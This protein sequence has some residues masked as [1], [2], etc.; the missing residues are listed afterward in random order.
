M[1]LQYHTL[2]HIPLADIAATFN[3]AFADYHVKLSIT[4]ERLVWKIKAE[5]ID[6]SL[7]TGVYDNKQMVGFILHATEERNGQ[8]LVYNGG[9]GVIPAYR[10]KQLVQGMY[11]SIQPL[12]KDRRVDALVLECIT[13]NIPAIK[14]YQR[15]GFVIKRELNCYKGVP[16]GE[17]AHT[18]VQ[19][20]SLGFLEDS[21][22]FCD[23]EPTWQ[24]TNNA[25]RRAPEEHQIF[26][27][28]K[29]G[30]VVAYAV[31]YPASL[32]IKQLAVHKDYRRQGMATSLLQYLKQ[33][34][35]ELTFTNVDSEC[36][37]LNALLT[38]RNMDNFVQ[39][40]EMWKQ[41]TDF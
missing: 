35:G 5:G 21:E 2:T 16:D 22:A 14:T 1:S 36:V 39:Q 31:Y 8:K 20:Q 34:S 23:T 27:I 30:A 3:Q 33:Q 25:I 7:S 6:L 24:H 37:S 17:I 9:T 12:M 15:L 11:G 10:G 38:G 13:Q 18:I 32:R 41:D 29:N 19:T 40:Y 26:T 28:E 4:E